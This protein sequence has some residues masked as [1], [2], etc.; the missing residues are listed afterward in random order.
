MFGENN[1]KSLLE[2]KWGS[3]RKHQFHFVFT[4][5]NVIIVMSY[6]HKNGYVTEKYPCW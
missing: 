4:V 2:V 3:N 5:Q 6:R 1:E